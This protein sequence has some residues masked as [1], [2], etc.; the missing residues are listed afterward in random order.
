MPTKEEVI[1]ALEKVDDPELQINLVD[2]GL[3]YRVEAGDDSVEVDMTL[4]APGCPVAGMI[5][6]QA[7]QAIKALGAQRV[8][9]NLV[10]EPRWTEERISDRLKKMRKMG[11]LRF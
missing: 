11:I 2:L 6:Q 9:V 1:K 10:W 4:T 3:I 5:V 7:E 8:Q